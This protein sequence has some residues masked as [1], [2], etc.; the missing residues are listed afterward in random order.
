M[1][2]EQLTDGF[3]GKLRAI[4][5]IAVAV[6]L[7]PAIAALTFTQRL[8]VGPLLKNETTIP[9]MVYSLVRKIFGYK[10]VF[11][12]ASQP[13][14][15]DKPTWFIGNHLSEADFIPFGGKIPGRFVGKGEILK[16]PLISIFAKTVKF[17][18]LRRSS[19][20][21]SQSRAKLIE[22][23]NEG[24]NVI[25]FP[26]GTVTPSRKIRMFRASLFSILYGDKG[27]DKEGKEHTL[28]KDV[29][30]Q[31]VALRV[32]SIN[33]KNALNSDE[34]YDVYGMHPQKGESGLKLIWR[35]LQIKN[36]TLE[37]TV[38]PPLD[39]KKF[40]DEKELVNRAALEIAR[41]VNPGQSKFERYKIPKYRGVTFTCK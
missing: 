15:K 16:W 18:G 6:A 27:I 26:E 3:R 11:N 35:N 34:L 38:L 29:A 36:I 32:L 23:F 8:V 28:K 2:K 19:K 14:V 30:V 1:Q 24:A 33:G 40:L 31:P 7:F 9:N 25:M 10:V 12:K 5:R 37:L 17:I 20:Y 22:A 39:P 41:S 4:S 21:N 13:I